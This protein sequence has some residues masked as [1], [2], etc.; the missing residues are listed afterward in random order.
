M[1]FWENRTKPQRH[2]KSSNAE[3]NIIAASEPFKKGHEK[4]NHEMPS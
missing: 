1:Y 3:S 4:M 2:N